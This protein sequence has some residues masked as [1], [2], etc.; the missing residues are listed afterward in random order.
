MA[1]SSGYDAGER[2]GVQEVSKPDYSVNS[3][4]VFEA[5]TTWDVDTMNLITILKFE[6]GFRNEPY[7][8]SEG[9]VTIGLGT[10]LHT[11]RGMD[12]EEFPIMVSLAQAEVWLHSEV[13]M[14]DMKLSR[15]SEG[16]IYNNLDDDRRAILLSMAYQMG[17]RGTL[18]FRNM[19][20]A[21][22][23]GDYTQAAREALNS[24]WARQTPERA[25]RHARVLRG[26]SIA[27][28]YSD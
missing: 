9:F 23:R 10:K 2:V 25:E 20:S 1:S 28:V 6:E 12:P 26:E 27:D 13:A 21:L 7:L 22:E 14:K 17:T 4:S 24:R 15:S 16:W 3:Q 8:C 19:W 18:K 5:L 11:S